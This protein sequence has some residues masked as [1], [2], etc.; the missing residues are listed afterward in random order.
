M[1]SYHIPFSFNVAADREVLW[2]ARCLEPGWPQVARMRQGAV[3]GA[4]RKSLAI[5]NPG[6]GCLYPR[7]P[8]GKPPGKVISFSFNS[9]ET[10]KYLCLNFMLEGRPRTML[11]GSRV[12]DPTWIMTWAS[13]SI[14]AFLGAFGE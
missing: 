9:A 10:R 13:S 1:R 8:H 3:R 6:W 12:S 11:K 14:T 2:E 4:E 7:A 5:P